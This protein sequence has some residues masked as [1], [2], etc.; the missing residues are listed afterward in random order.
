MK[1]IHPIYPD[2]K[3]FD[4]SNQSKYSILVFLKRQYPAMQTLVWRVDSVTRA[5]MA[6][7]GPV[8]GIF[9]KYS[10]FYK[11]RS[12]CCLRFKVSFESTKTPDFIYIKHEIQHEWLHHYL[13]CSEK[14]LVFLPPVTLV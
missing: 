2:Y 12:Y 4:F 8:Y 11:T 5:C 9:Q 14:P 10:M 7:A 13:H 1:V 3:R 6:L